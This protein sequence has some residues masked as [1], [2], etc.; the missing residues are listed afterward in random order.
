MVLRPVLDQA[1]QRI[2]VEAEAEARRAKVRWKVG[3][4]ALV[5][6]PMPRTTY[7]EREA[8]VVQLVTTLLQ[9][10]P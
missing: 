6:L 1:E 8:R 10:T 5:R 7:L 4:E 2:P 9:E 3:D